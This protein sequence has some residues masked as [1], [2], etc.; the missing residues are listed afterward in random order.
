VTH[1]LGLGF[2]DRE[3]VRGCARLRLDA[4]GSLPENSGLLLYL[5]EVLLLQAQKTSCIHKIG[6]DPIGRLILLEIGIA[7]G[8][9]A[10]DLIL[11]EQDS[12]S[13][14]QSR[15]RCF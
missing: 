6:V 3:V 10:D 2:R 13:F 11:T 14:F 15:M 4:K 5:M 12:C 8:H 1:T 9:E 7:A